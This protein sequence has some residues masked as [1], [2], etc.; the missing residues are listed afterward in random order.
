MDQLVVRWTPTSTDNTWDTL[1][2]KTPEFP[3]ENTIL[4]MV[5]YI[6]IAKAKEKLK[7]LVGDADEKLKENNQRASSF[8]QLLSE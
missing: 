3:D 6:L 8:I 2:K 4:L 5:R 1:P 7:R